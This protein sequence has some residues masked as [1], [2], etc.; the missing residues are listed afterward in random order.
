MLLLE[1]IMEILFL[2]GRILFGGFFVM[3]GVNHLKKLGMLT[4][5]AQ[6][7]SVPSAKFAVFFTGLLLLFGGLGVILGV[8]VEWAV[9]A[10]VVF[11][12]GVSFKMHNFWADQDPN[13]KMSNLVN[14][15]KNMA[16]LGAAL[17]LLAIP[18]PWPYSVFW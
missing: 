1:I 11:L 4:G 12:V 7:K 9:L 17:V 15:N 14:F 13:M 5:Y 10:L 3:N 16:L 8:W 6:S 2:V 18:A